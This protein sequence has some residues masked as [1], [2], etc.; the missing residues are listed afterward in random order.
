MYVITW[1]KQE[2]AGAVL[3]ENVTNTR[4]KREEIM[5][6]NKAIKIIRHEIGWESKSSTI[7]AF[8]E[9]VKA[10]EEIQQYRAIGTV[11]ECQ[12]AV[13]KQTANKPIDRGLYME[14]PNCGEIRIQDCGYCSSCGQKIDWSDEE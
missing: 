7:S 5:E 3:W 6:A 1:Q 2:K 9:A 4:K 10:L 14:C 11:E 8:E 12:A 13:E